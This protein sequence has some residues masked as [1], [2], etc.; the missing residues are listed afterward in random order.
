MA[1]YGSTRTHIDV[2]HPDV[3]SSIDALHPWQA[4]LKVDSMAPPRGFKPSNLGGEPDEVSSKPAYRAITIEW[5]EPKPW[6][7]SDEMAPIMNAEIKPGYLYAISWDHHRAA[8]SETIAYIGITKNLDRRF[9]NHPTAEHLRAR[10]RKTFLSIGHIDFGRWTTASAATRQ[11]TEELEH[12]L[13]WTLWET[14]L[15][16]RKMLCIPGYGTRRGGAWHITNK[17]HSFGGQMP[18]EII[19]PWILVKPRRRLFRADT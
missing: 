11:V 10:K 13:V 4:N 9:H 19:Y 6:G 18:L 14:L 15:N 5:T 1:T 17:G 12:L 2:L 16:D 7:A 8:H 3:R